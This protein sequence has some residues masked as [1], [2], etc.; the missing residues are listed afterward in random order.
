[1][2]WSLAEMSV[3]RMHSHVMRTIR[4]MASGIRRAAIAPMTA[5]SE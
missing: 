1:M 5:A 3:P 4:P 2:F